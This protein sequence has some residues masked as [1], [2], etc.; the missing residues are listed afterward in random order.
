MASQQ[1]EL[2]KM[3]KRMVDAMNSIQS[4]VDQDALA[5]QGGTLKRLIEDGYNLEAAQG[6]DRFHNWG[7][8]H[9]EIYREI[10]QQLPDYDKSDTDGYS[11]QLY[12]YTLKQ[13]PAD[14]NRP[15]K[16]L[17]VGCN[18]GKG[19]NFLSR[20]EGRSTF[21]GL[22][23]SQQAVNIA[24]ARFS[25]PGSLTYVQGDAENLPFADGEFDVVINVESSHNYPNLRQSF[26]EVA[27]VL[28]PGGFFSHV[29]VFSD[30]RYSVMQNCKQQTSNELDW[31]KETDLSEYVKE[32][33]RRRLAPGSK[34]RQ[35]VER[36]LPYPLG[37]LFSSVMMR[38][39][40]SEFAVGQKSDDWSRRFS[41]LNPPGQQWLSQITSY[42]HTLATRARSH[43]S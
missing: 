1:I 36:A 26:L 37:K 23:L 31:L 39:Y 4:A 11:E 19:L 12:V 7:M 15:R 30:N 9:E 16:I 14:K 25:R 28:R 5:A 8:F 27:R 29:D 32:A 41:W 17:E 40:G 10:L 22:D 38:G 42:R 2:I 35:Q 21:V 24:N 43:G 34:A 18:S 20:F 33:I 3:F 6:A 13:V